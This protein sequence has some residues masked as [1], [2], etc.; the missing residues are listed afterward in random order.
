MPDWTRPDVTY[1]DIDASHL[2]IG[3][4]APGQTTTGHMAS[5]HPPQHL[6]IDDTS[7]GG[8]GLVTERATGPLV[9][10]DQ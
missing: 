3:Q 1:Q 4:K 2:L 6:T 9:G 5:Q 10:R 7:L 8:L